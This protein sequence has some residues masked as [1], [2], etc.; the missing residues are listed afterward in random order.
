MKIGVSLPNWSDDKNRVPRSRLVSYAKKAEQLGFGGLWMG[1]HLLAPDT[2][3]HSLMEPLTTLSHIA[4]ETEKIPLGT[5]ILVLTLRQPVVAAKQVANMQYLSEGRI[6]VGVGLGYYEPEFDAVDIPYEARGKVLTESL[7]LF[8]ELL[9]EREVSYDGEFYNVEN[10]TIHPQ[11]GRVPRIL[12]GGAGVV[13]SSGN[14]YVRTGGQNEDTD[15]ERFVPT[16]IKKRM[17]MVDGW[18]AHGETS[19]ALRQDWEEFA[20]YLEEHGQDPSKKDKVAATNVY[21]EPNADTEAAT[22]RQLRKYEQFLSEDR[23]QSYARTHYITGSVEDVRNRLQD[24]DD[25][26]FDE[27]VAYNRLNSLDELDRQLKLWAD[28]FPEYF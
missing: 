26:G 27:L 7:E 9:N 2:Y 5:S 3:N 18:L 13:R 23:G 6:T 12:Y 14:D 10:V 4:G 15:T 28:T 1:D 24:Y 11:L 21:I 16:P 8:I 25:Q 19:E 17:A 22:K 20:A